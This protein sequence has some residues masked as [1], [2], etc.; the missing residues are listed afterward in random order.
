MHWFAHLHSLFFYIFLLG[1][2]WVPEDYKIYLYWYW[3]L[4]LIAWLLLDRCPL[5]YLKSKE[6][7]PDQ[8]QAEDPFKDKDDYLIHLHDLGW[9]DCNDRL[10][11]Y[12]ETII[13]LIS[14]LAPLLV[15]LTLGFY[16][17]P[18]YIFSFIILIALYKRC[19]NAII[20]CDQEDLNQDDNPDEASETYSLSSNI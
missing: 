9:L 7:T 16:P 17:I 20:N 12:Q 1:P 10:L 15:I 11:K 8:D 4:N 19:H 13:R 14:G 6:S 3:I 5:F 18:T 2:F